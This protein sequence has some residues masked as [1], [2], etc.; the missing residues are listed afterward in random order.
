MIFSIVIVAGFLVVIAVI[1]GVLAAFVAH[2]YF[3]DW[4]PERM[5]KESSGILGGI[6]CALTVFGML[7]A[8]NPD[9]SEDNAGR[10]TVGATATQTAFSATLW[11]PLYLYAYTAMARRR[12]WANE[13]D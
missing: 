5:S 6:F 3:W 1:S 2:G 13:A 9:P 11:L 12:R 4:V 7:W 10:P 8:I